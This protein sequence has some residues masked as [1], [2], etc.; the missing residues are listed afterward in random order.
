MKLLFA[1]AAALALLLSGCAT[2]TFLT[3]AVPRQECNA[4]YAEVIAVNGDHLTVSAEDEI[5]S[6]QVNT[7]LLHDWIPGDEVVL[8]Y[9]GQFGEDEME[10]RYIDK[11]TENSEVQRPEDKQKS[12]AEENGGAVVG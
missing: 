8:Y 2:G 12:E 1:A 5:F 6:A 10:I 7:R 9:T 3:G 11:W 4:I